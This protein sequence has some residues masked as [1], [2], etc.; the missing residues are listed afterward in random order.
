MGVWGMFIFSPIIAIWL[1][2]VLERIPLEGLV[3]SLVK[4]SAGELVSL[5]EL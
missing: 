2:V 5:Y 3:G 4:V 1:T